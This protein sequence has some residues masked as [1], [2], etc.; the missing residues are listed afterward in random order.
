MEALSDPWIQKN[1]ISFPLNRKILTNL[2]QF[3]IN[4][5][6]RHAI[7]TFMANRMIHK[8]DLEQLENAFQSLDADGNG[9][10]TKEELIEGYCKTMKEMP[11]HDIIKEVD[12]IIG[13]IDSNHS[14]EIDFT[15]F[16][17]A[18]INKDKL[19]EGNYIQKGFQLFDEDGDGFIDI[20]ELK[21]VMNGVN[22]TDDEWREVIKQFDSD[23]D[24]KVRFFINLRFLSRSFPI[25]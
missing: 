6:F 16:L 25:C 11:M 20:G 17:V 14:G 12:R 8:Q 22:L 10:L 2:S 4:S 1:S 24:G 3:H 23:N 18:A 9:I 5:R 21:S 13:T 19:L 7:M 15:E